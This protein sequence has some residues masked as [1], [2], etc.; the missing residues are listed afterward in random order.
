MSNP[1][2][3]QERVKEHAIKAVELDKNGQYESAIIYY[4]VNR[5]SFFFVFFF[6][7]LI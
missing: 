6:S 7:N 1:V 4:L 3:L 2:S 5:L